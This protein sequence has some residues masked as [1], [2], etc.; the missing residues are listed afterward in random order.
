M[1]VQAADLGA[2][3]YSIAQ[4]ERTPDGI[5]RVKV[6]LH[7]LITTMLIGG[8]RSP[9]TCV[10]FLQMS[11]PELDG[12]TPLEWRPARREPAVLTEYAERLT[13]HLRQICGPERW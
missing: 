11:G 7:G 10:V 12:P 2:A 6:G 1:R 5:V 13:E 8:Y 9:Q 4:F 3:A